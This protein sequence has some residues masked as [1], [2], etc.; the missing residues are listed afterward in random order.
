[1]LIVCFVLFIVLLVM[2]CF[3]VEKTL[4]GLLNCHLKCFEKMFVCLG[5]ELEELF[6]FECFYL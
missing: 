5:F 2:K 6:C 3:S 1:M 4:E